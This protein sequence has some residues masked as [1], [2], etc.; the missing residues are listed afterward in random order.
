MNKKLFT[1]WLGVFLYVVL[2]G[3]FVQKIFLPYIFPQAHWGHGLMIGGDWIQFHKEAV[4]IA[5]FLREM[6]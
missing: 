2:S 4:E 5:S 6:D 3:F 1:I